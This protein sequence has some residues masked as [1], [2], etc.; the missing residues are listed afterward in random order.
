MIFKLWCISERKTCADQHDD[1]PALLSRHPAACDYKALENRTCPYEYEKL[2]SCP[3]HK[4]FAYQT[5]PY[6]CGVCEP[7]SSKYAHIW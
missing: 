6:T 5:C 7:D 4:A 3:D 1:C 2:D